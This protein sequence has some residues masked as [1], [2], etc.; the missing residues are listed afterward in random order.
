MKIKITELPQNAGTILRFKCDCGR[1]EEHLLELVKEAKD[2]GFQDKPK[3]ELTF[4]QFKE[5][6]EIKVKDEKVKK[7]Y[8]GML[9]LAWWAYI[10]KADSSQ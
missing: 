5:E 7:K 6:W 3:W 10:N 9:V 4:N 1:T 8:Q 2:K